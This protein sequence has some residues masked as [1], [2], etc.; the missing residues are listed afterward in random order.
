MHVIFYKDFYL[1]KYM[2][3]CIRILPDLIIKLIIQLVVKDVACCKK[4]NHKTLNRERNWLKLVLKFAH[5]TQTS[6]IFGSQTQTKVF[7][8]ESIWFSGSVDNSDYWY[9]NPDRTGI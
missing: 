5:S 8:Y 1:I 7:N 4:T 3:Y 6:Q 9:F 2:V